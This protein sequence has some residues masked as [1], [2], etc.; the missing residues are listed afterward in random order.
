M[1]CALGALLVALAAAWRRLAPLARL[2]AA[3]AG[4]ALLAA[5]GA[6]LAAAPGGGP[7]AYLHICGL[8]GASR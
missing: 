8:E 4:A 5:S 7:L 1:C 2:G 6:A 3:A